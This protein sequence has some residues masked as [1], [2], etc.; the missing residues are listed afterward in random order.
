MG[1]RKFCTIHRRI[2]VGG[3]PEC[4]EQSDRDTREKE[5]RRGS[6][7]KR[8]YGHKWRKMTDLWLRQ[9]ENR[10]CFYCLQKNPPKKRTPTV[11]DHFIPHKGDLNLFWDRSNWR[12]SC[13]QCHDRKTATEDGGFGR[14]AVER[15]PQHPQ[16]Q[17]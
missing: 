12:P 15:Q 17:E 11:V 14:P 2:D 4:R 13:K 6:A 10:N 16:H 9:R 7:A 3:C 5:R 8:L 1:H